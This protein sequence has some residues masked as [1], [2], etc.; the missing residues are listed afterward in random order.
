MNI[1][2]SFPYHAHTRMQ[3]L[4]NQNAWGSAR[5]MWQHWHRITRL[6]VSHL[7]KK[8][9]SPKLRPRVDVT[10]ANSDGLSSMFWVETSPTQIHRDEGITWI[11]QHHLDII[12]PES[13]IAWETPATQSVLSGSI[14]CPHVHRLDRCNRSHV[15]DDAAPFLNL[16]Q[17]RAQQWDNNLI[18]I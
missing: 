14:C 15:D 12:F 16:T 18:E 7:C 8:I 1:C 17:R 10:G 4:A 9:I 5:T 2:I 6:Q 11:H 13:L 3:V